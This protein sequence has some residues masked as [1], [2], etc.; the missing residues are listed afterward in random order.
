VQWGPI[1]DSLPWEENKREE[2]MRRLVRIQ[3]LHIFLAAVRGI[4]LLVSVSC[5]P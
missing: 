4:Y 1:C 3:Y 5:G 2:G